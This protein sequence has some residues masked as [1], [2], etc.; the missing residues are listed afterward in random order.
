M[1]DSS[2][3]AQIGVGGFGMYLM[4][5]LVALELHRLR[6]QI[7]RHDEAILEKFDELIEKLT[8]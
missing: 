1:I 8:S 5:R 3:Y 6:M 2:I 4:Y 7:Q